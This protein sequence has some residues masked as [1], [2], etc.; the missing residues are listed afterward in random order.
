MFH[1]KLCEEQRKSFVLIFILMLA[2]VSFKVY[3][4][5]NISPKIGIYA[6]SDKDRVT[7]RYMFEA[8]FFL[9]EIIDRIR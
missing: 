5:S 3:A 9:R 1:V 2:A 4:Q 6:G 7:Y 8:L